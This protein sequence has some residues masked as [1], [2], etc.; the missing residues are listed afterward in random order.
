MVSAM[1][2]FHFLWRN[3]PFQKQTNFFQVVGFAKVLPDSGRDFFPYSLDLLEL[4]LRHVSER[5]HIS[6]RF[7]Q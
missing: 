4:F 7:C 1:R 5:I 3:S 6:R 2:F